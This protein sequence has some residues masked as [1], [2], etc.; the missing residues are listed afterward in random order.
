MPVPLEEAKGHATGGGCTTWAWYRLSLEEVGGG[1]DT[2]TAR[3][4]T[5]LVE[6]GGAGIFLYLLAS[7]Y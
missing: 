3:Y 6:E 1:G 2:D 7:N 4:P 5:P